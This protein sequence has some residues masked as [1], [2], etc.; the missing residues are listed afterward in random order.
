MGR[1]A[2]SVGILEL[3]AKLM[4][5]AQAAGVVRK[6]AEPTDVPMMMCALAGIHSGPYANPERYIGLVLDGFRVT[7]QKRTKLPPPVEA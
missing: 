7:G 5:R 6:D 4:G 3:T 2:E 1:A